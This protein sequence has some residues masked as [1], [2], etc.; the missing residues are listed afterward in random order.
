MRIFV[1][2]EIDGEIGDVFRKLL[3]EIDEKFKPLENKDYGSGY[4]FICIIPIIINPKRGLFEKDF[5]KERKLIKRKLKEADIRLRTD[6][7]K[8]F[9]A[10]Y[11]KKRLLLL[12]NI[13]RSIRVIGDGSKSNFNS[14]KLIDD[15]CNVFKIDEKELVGL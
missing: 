4:I 2:G 5:F 9:N 1:S 12:E 13:I 3:R 8:F 6:S 7:D 10:D 15:I 14:K 11:E